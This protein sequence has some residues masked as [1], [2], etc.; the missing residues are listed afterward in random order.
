MRY[1]YDIV[2][3]LSH[4]VLTPFPKWV[5]HDPSCLSCTFHSCSKPGWSYHTK[6][7]QQRGAVY[8]HRP[9]LLTQNVLQQTRAVNFNGAP[10]SCRLTSKETFRIVSDCTAGD[11]VFRQTVTINMNYV[12]SKPSL[13]LHLSYLRLPL[14]QENI[15][16]STWLR[17]PDLD[18]MCRSLSIPPDR[19]PPFGRYVTHVTHLH[20][21][22][23]RW[24]LVC[25]VDHLDSCC[26][27]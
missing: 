19:M 27:L 13:V 8:P 22:A 15:P 23:H 21:S 14:L 12:G 4:W 2:L 18:H 26:T 20:K 17:D 5:Q 16:L 3:E 24:R 9:V 25:K 7:I 11:S 6:L 10:L 1:S